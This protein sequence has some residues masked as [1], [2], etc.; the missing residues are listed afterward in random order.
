MQKNGISHTSTKKAN[1]LK[2]KVKQFLPYVKNFSLLD[3]FMHFFLE[4]CLKVIK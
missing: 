1:K 4:M 3:I 2:S